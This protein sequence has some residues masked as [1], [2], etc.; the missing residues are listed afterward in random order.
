MSR[1]RG[2]PACTTVSYLS[3]VASHGET[4]VDRVAL[5]LPA[6]GTSPRES[7]RFVARQ[8]DLWGLEDCVDALVLLVSELVT[9]ALLHARTDM[10]VVVV[11]DGDSTVRLEVSDG[12]RALPAQR[13]YSEFAGTGRGLNMV[14]AL[15]AGWGVRVEGR[16]K[17]VWAIVHSGGDTADDSPKFFDAGSLGAL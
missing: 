1:L 2:P 7:R 4:Q 6:A 9:N 14:D 3:G 5:T 8:L 12:S 16:G 15:A 13:R 11:R 10:T 17:T